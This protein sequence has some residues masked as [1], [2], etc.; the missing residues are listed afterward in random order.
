MVSSVYLTHP[1]VVVDPKVPVSDWGLNSAGSA[2]TRANAHRFKGMERIVTSTEQK[3]RDAGVIIAES[4][5][6]PFEAL[7][8]FGENDRSATGYLP[9]IEFWPVVEA[10]FAKPDESARGWKTACEEQTRIVTSVTAALTEQNVP[11]LFV[12]HG[13]VGSLLFAHLANHPLG[14]KSTLSNG[15]GRACGFN[16]SGITR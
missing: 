4:C 12:G 2:R 16:L 11:T 7:P 3:A 10:F 13:G 1:E 6:I 5:G 15:M 8:G 9:E 14:E